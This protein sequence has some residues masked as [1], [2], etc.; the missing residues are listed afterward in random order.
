MV[1]NPLS[2]AGNAVVVLPPLPEPQVPDSSPQESFL[3]YNCEF[4]PVNGGGDG[5]SYF[6]MLIGYSGQQT[7][8]HLYGLQDMSWVSAAVQL[9][10]TPPRMQVMLFDESKFY[11]LVTINKILVCDFP[12]LSIST[13]D[14]PN[15]VEHYDA[16]HSIMLSRGGGSGIFLIHVKESLLRVFKSDNLGSWFLV[17]SIC[18]HEVCSNLGVSDWLSLNG[19]TH[20]VKIYAVG[21]NAKFVFLDVFGTI[22]FLDITSKQADKVY[23]I[24]EDEELV[25]VHALMLTWPPTFPQLKEGYEQ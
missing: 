14:L 2:P 23:E 21:D 19:Q 8:V 10:V 6:C 9:P 7:A 25:D 11:I 16:S 15:G 5:R 12:S 22:V 18:L 4:L 13:M 24:Q 17:R 3:Y 20:G 1:C